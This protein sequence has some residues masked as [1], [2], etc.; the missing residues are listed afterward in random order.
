MLKKLFNNLKERFLENKIK[1]SILILKSSNRSPKKP[2]KSIGCIVDT[3]LDLDYSDILDLAIEMGL[4]EKDI[5]I[6]SYSNSFYNDPFCKMRISDKSVNF[7][8]N[9]ISPDVEEFTSSSYDM[10]INYFGNNRI[11]TLLSSKTRAKFR[12]GFDSSNQNINDIIFTDIF[13]NFGKFR[14]QLIKYLKYIK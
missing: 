4:K 8:G 14:N 6:I 10:L 13:N 12:V 11:L 2:I 5:K 7:Y 1:E 3:N 9:I